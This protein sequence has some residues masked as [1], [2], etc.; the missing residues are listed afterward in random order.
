MDTYLLFVYNANA[1]YWNGVMDSLHKI[2]SPKTYPCSLCAITYGLRKIEPDWDEFIKTELKD[3]NPQ[4][5]HKDELIAEFG[6]EVLEQY[7]LPAV[8]WV[9]KDSK[10]LSPIIPKEELNQLKLEDL[11]ERLRTVIANLENQL[12]QAD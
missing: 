5:L 10:G 2:F 6:K 7:P 12:D 4:F 3:F 8:F 9:E 1:G 11:K